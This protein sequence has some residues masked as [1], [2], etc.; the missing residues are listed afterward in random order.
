MKNTM[1]N[2]FLLYTLLSAQILTASDICAQNIHSKKWKDIAYKQPIEWYASDEAS[3]IADSVLKY[4]MPNGGWPKN[5][6]WHIGADQAYMQ[7]CREEGIDSTS[8]NNATTSEMKFLCRMYNSKKDERYRTAFIH[9]LEYILKAQYANGG[10]PQFFPARKGRSV[11]YSS[12][13][14]FNDG[15]MTN[16]LKL[17]ENISDGNTIYDNL[18]IPDTLKTKAHEAYKRGVQCILDC[19]YKQD[20]KLTVWCQQHDENTLLPA[21]A[22]AYELKSLSGHGETVDILQFL[23]SIPNPSDSICRS[24]KSAVE[25]LKKSAIKDTVIEKYTDS[26]GR[27]DIRP[28][29]KKG[30]PD[31]WAR[32]YSIETGKPIF[33][34]R[35][36]IAKSS[37]EEIGYER[38]NGY[39]WYGSSP[40]KIIDAYKDWLER[41]GYTDSE[42]Q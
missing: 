5:Q 11:A 13:I 40:Q 28:V 2:T 22:R 31:I 37:I 30:A 12:H 27:T 1:N 9:G 16:I 41:N 18:N 32:F 4:Q 3:A 19:Q 20:G 10:W 34:D 29:Y 36:G 6:E 33:C 25:W 15:A 42:Q 23:M 24:I 26:E 21:P 8:D 38:R 35:D 14:T 17:L 39:R 7:K